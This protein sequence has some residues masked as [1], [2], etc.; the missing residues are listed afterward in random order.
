MTALA[1]RATTA[2]ALSTALYLMPAPDG[3]RLLGAFADAEAWVTWAD[4]RMERWP[5]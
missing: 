1:A 4:G 5:G 2:D 3:R